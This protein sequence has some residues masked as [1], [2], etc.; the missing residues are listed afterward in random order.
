[1]SSALDDDTFIH[2]YKSPV[3]VEARNRPVILK[4]DKPST[5]TSSASTVPETQMLSYFNADM[6][7]ST[8]STTT[9]LQ[10]VIPE[11]Q[12]VPDFVVSTQRGTALPDTQLITCDSAI[13][14]SQYL[15]LSETPMESGTALPDTAMTSFSE[16]PLL[17]VDHIPQQISTVNVNTNATIKENTLITP[18]VTNQPE[19]GTVLLDISGLGSDDDGDDE[20]TVNTQADLFSDTNQD[21]INLPEEENEMNNETPNDD[22]DNT[23]NDSQVTGDFQ[24]SRCFLEFNQYLVYTKHINTCQGPKR[25][26]RCIQPG[27][28]LEFSQR[29][30][31]MQ[32]N[33]SV[34]L[35]QPFFCPHKPCNHRYQSQKA[36]KAH[37]K[38]H[39]DKCFKFKCTVCGQKFI[40]KGQYNIHLTRHTNVKP[41]A[42]N[43]C[44]RATYTTAAQLSQHVALCMFGSSFRCE[45]CGKSF[46]SQT[47]LKQHHQTVHSKSADFSCDL[48]PHVY[49]QYASLWK[50]RRDKHGNL[51][52]HAY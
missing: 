47:T 35:H 23:E 1:M 31:M 21:E 49:K 15:S 39:H 34:H 25:K 29:S 4:S 2:Q 6:H 52:M 19:P 16:T 48:C 36:L 20:T 3:K 44:K 28:N 41:F 42:C 18:L 51:C 37:I 43:H 13:P 45:M 30:I 50:H 9:P 10:A 27:C 5:V 38:E 33:R 12:G 7:S 40:H 8:T 14:A 22:P 32:H 46:S 17:P 26:F 11:T 24:C